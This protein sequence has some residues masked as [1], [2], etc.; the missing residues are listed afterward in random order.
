MD[1]FIINGKQKL[2]GKITVSGAKNSALKIIA[3]T[4]LLKEPVT[5]SNVPDLMDVRTMQKVLEKLGATVEYCKDSSTMKID[6]STINSYRAPYEL[7]KTMRASFQVMGPLLARFGNAEIS[8][9]GGCNF[10]PRPVDFHLKAFEQ[11]GATI[12]TEHGYICA[13]AEKLIGN[14][15]YFDFPSVGATE[16]VIMAASLTEGVTIIENAAK[17]PEVVDLVNFLKLCG[18]KIQGEGTGR[19]RIE[20]VKELQARDFTVLSDRIEAGTFV[21]ASLVTNSPLEIVGA[22]ISALEVFLE[23]LRL[24]GHE[25]EVHQHSLVV[26]PSP[27]PKAI[28]FTALPHPGFPTDLQAPMTAYLSTVE[29]TSLATEG[30]YENR[31]VYISELNRM[32]ASIELDG[33]KA[34]ISGQEQLSG[35]QVMASDLRAGAA[36]VIA[37]LGAEGTTEINRVYHIDRGYDDL[38]G[39][40]SDV[41]ANIQRVKR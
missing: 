31:F 16:N 33:N 24:C 4:I 7:V 13:K 5:I 14:H 32:G 34:Y 35:A 23:K 38:V 19:V 29:G 37:A 3:A 28:K 10:G 30:V 26:K 8:L 9:P 15:I 21:L 17:E 20:G 39:K 2:S 18:A 12:T 40:L 11:M 22:P 1:K 27:N 6:P 36:L 41:G 25:F